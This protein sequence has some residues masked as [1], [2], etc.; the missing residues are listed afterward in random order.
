MRKDK[1]LVLLGKAFKIKFLRR[2]KKEKRKMKVR[3][4]LRR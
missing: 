3:N 2:K 4:N 1:N